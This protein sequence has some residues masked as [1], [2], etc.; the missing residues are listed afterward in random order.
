LAEQT[1]QRKEPPFKSESTLKQGLL[2][3]YQPEYLS[4][5]I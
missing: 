1:T 2:D 4:H 3:L 5:W